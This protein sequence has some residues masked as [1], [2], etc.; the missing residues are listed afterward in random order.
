[1]ASTSYGLNRKSK[2]VNRRQKSSIISDLPFR[3]AIFGK[4]RDTNIQ[5]H[6]SSQQPCISA[7][8]PMVEQSDFKQGG[9]I[10]PNKICEVTTFNLP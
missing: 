3:T 8:K 7:L 10:T 9:L 4:E 5:S 6:Q 2:L 1:M